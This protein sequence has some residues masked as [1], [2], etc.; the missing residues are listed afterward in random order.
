MKKLTL[1]VTL[2]SILTFSVYSQE[3][4]EVLKTKKGRVIMPE[5]GDIGLSID[6][7]PF[8]SYAGNLFNQ[9][10]N[11]AP[12]F[13]FTA[14]DPTSLTLKYFLK[15]DMAVRATFLLGSSRNVVNEPSISDPKK[16]DKTIYSATAFGF[17]GGIEYSRSIKNRLRGYY[18]GLVGFEYLPYTDD[19]GNTGNVKYI[20]AINVKNDTKII[21]G[22][23]STIYIA[24][25]VGVEYFF[26]SK[27]SIGGEFYFSGGFGS[28]SERRQTFSNGSEDNISQEKSNGMGFMTSASGALKLSFHF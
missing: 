27:I 3:T 15:Q 10:G 25:L 28:T 12:T 4:T 26:A 21:G 14:Q 6:A 17:S 11:T 16:L 13:N 24:G 9:N 5:A 8:L 2:L 20:D 19:L 23:T 1:I 7:T 22:N 18:G